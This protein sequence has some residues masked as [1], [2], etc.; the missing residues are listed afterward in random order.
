M[1]QI[2]INNISLYYEVYGQGEPIVFIAG[3]GADHTVWA[4]LITRFKNTHQVIVFDNRGAGQTQAPEGPYT[5]EQMAEDVVELCF[6]LGIKKAH[7]IGTSMGGFILQ[8]LAHRYESLVKSAVI[9]H[10]AA[11]AHTPFAI[12]VQAQLALLQENIMPL[13]VIKALCSWLFSFK[14]HH[15]QVWTTY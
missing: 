13:A 2:K 14:F 15:I 8:I 9:S 3:F 6:K 1:G 11:I 7:F 12:Y 10:S 4:E 5:I